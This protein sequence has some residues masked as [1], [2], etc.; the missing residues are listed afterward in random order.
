MSASCDI[1]DRR[2]LTDA[3]EK[4]RGALF[5]IEP[6]RHPAMPRGPPFKDQIDGSCSYAVNLQPNDLARPARARPWCDQCNMTPAKRSNL[7]GDYICAFASIQ[8]H[9]KYS[10]RTLP[11]NTSSAMAQSD[12]EE[13][14][15]SFLRMSES[16]ICARFFLTKSL[17]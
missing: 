17:A 6:M 11:G 7:Y 4:S 9:N 15:T 3:G 13:G 5:I 8:A 2:I 14:L 1:S 16:S 12:Q 10:I